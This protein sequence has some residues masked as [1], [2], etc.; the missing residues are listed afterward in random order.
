VEAEGSTDTKPLPGFT[1]RQGAGLAFGLLG[2]SSVTPPAGPDLRIDFQFDTAAFY[3]K[4]L[5]FTIPYPV[6]FRLLGDETKGWLDITYMSPDGQFR[7]SRGNKGTLFVLVKDEP[8]REAMLSAIA[9]RAR[10]ADIE[11]LVE[12]A[13]AQRGG[14]K[15]PAASP[16]AVGRW[17]LRWTKQ[18]ASANPLQR[19]LAGKVRNWQIIT[20]DGRL[21]NRVQLAPGVTVRAL[22]SC[23]ADAPAR[24]GV[25]IEKVVVEVGPLRFNIPFTAAPRGFVDWLY[26]DDGLRITRGSKGSLFVHTRDEM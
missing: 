11:A 25:T 18:D 8:P 23:G 16:V 1:P 17:R 19:A 4:S 12:A 3:F 21:E 20:E 26:L 7:L 14:V 24:T 6:P 13:A 15:N 9:G 22:A 10:D 2:I 5:P